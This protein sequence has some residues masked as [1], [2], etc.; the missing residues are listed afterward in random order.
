MN[1]LHHRTSQQALTK[2]YELQGFYIKCGQLI[3]ANAGNGFPEIW[4][5][6]MSILQDQC[7]PKDFSVILGIITHELD[8][9][10][11]F[12]SIEES[13]IGSASMDK[14]IVRN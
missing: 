7:P 4:Q 9:D 2:I 5:Q 8:V 11:I 6:T 13:P 10:Q 3:A 12:D 1:Q 14:Y